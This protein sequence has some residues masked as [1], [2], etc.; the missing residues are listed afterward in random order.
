MK[1]RVFVFLFLITSI[2]CFSQDFQDDEWYQ[3]KPIRDIIFT[4]LRNVTQ[5]ELEPLMNQYKGRNFN[6]DIFWEIQGR[7]Y[8]LE[9]F[10]RIEPSTVRANAAGSEVIIRFN[11]VERPSIDR[12]IFSGN[13][14]LTR[15]ELNDVII[16]RIN[17]ILNQSRVRLDIEAITNKYIEKGYPNVSVTATESQSGESSV[18]LIFT[19]VEREQISI[20]RIEFQGNSRFSNNT[21]RGQLSLKQRGIINDGAF[22]ESK[23]LA[24]RES[25]TKYYHDRGFIDARVVDVTRTFETDSKR[26]NMIL[27]FMISEGT[28]FKFGGV[29][30]EGNIIF[31]TDQLSRLVSSRVGDI[32]NMTRL[33]MDLQR[34]ADLYFENGYIYNSFIRTPDRNNQ[35]NVLSFQI[36]IIERSRAYIE[37]IIITGNSKTKDEVILRE[38]PMEPGD[39]FSRTKILDAMRNLYNLQ[40]FSVVIPDSLQGS[41]E[42]LM[43]LVFT[44]EEQPTTDVQFGFSF[45]GNT[46]PES[47]PI[48]GLLKW[49]DRN[50]AG[51]GNQLGID[52][53][54]SIIDTTAISVNYLHRWVFGLPLSLGVDFTTSFS[55]RFATMNNSAPWFNGDERYAFPDGFSSYQEY[56]E[57]RKIPTRDYLMMYEQIY[58]SLGLTSGYRWST[59]NGI[60]GLNGGM[61]F[62]ITRNSY[63]DELYRP[64]DPVLRERNNQW[65]PKNS[66]WAA[67]SLDDRDIF[68]DPSTGYY[69]YNRNSFM[70]VL[71]SER[72][73]YI[74]SDTKAQY[75]LTLFDKPVTENW[76]FKSVLAFHVGLSAIIGQP[77]RSLKIEDANKL[78]VDGM[79]IGRG[80]NSEFANKGLLLLDTWVEMRFPLIK[81]ILAFDLFFEGAGVDTEEGD[82]FS[83]FSIENM[84]FGFGGGFRFAIP[85]F[86]IRISVVKRFKVIDGQIDLQRGAI[87]A[88]D[89]DS[90]GGVDISMSFVMSY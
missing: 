11:V 58:L 53:N 2:L 81:G 47:F 13:S 77:G 90:K 49:N 15:R 12:I 27:T 61:R 56:I 5:A 83:T 78:A 79:F 14:G 67:V 32:V 70:G 36:T 28:E 22:Q 54:S 42:N 64:F 88:G 18:T 26:T 72:E 62:G 31:S 60:F 48:S 68:Y 82:Y 9:F 85:Q 57:N 16:S 23:L 3:G 44:F 37:N 34:V 10:D 19:I 45:T 74:R 30:F 4:G 50:L 65:T 7:L 76:N 21:L 89:R 41:A 87:F 51:S 86:P 35:T 43:D 40:F 69:L 33:E 39:V 1:F 38:I 46:D 17:G 55:K 20:S 63:D 24:D 25:I 75:Y 6:D 80:W 8:A 29:S 71:P 52:I 84:R 73:H 59:S 66:V